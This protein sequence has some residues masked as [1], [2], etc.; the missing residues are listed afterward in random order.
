[1][2]T[3]CGVA[4]GLAI[5]AAATGLLAAG[6]CAKSPTEVNVT[7]EVDQTAPPIRL[8]HSRIALQSAPQTVAIHKIASRYEGDAG[9]AAPFVFP[10]LY[11]VPVPSGW[12]GDVVIIVNGVDWHDDTTVLATG[13]TS[14]TVTRQQTTAASVT[15]TAVATGGGDGGVLSDAGDASGTEVDAPGDAGSSDA[16]D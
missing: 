12:A 6:G 11:P 7:V 5:L 2:N 10:M 9:L 1:M 14:A 4:R 8:L 15:L 13:T 3:T 16:T